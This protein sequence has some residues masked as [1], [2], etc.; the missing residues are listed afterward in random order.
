MG[1]LSHICLAFVLVALTQAKRSANVEVKDDTTLSSECIQSIKNGNYKQ[2]AT[3]LEA[4][5]N[6]NKLWYIVKELSKSNKDNYFDSL[7]RFSENVNSPTR[8]FL[9]YMILYNE[10]ESCDTINVMHLL[11]LVQQ[12]RKFSAST[13]LVNV[14]ELVDSIHSSI[15]RVI[16]AK[17]IGEIM[18]GYKKFSKTTT[19]TLNKI[20]EYDQEF[21]SLIVKAVVMELNEKIDGSQILNIFENQ[22]NLPLKT[23]GILATY[24]ALKKSNFSNSDSVFALALSIKKL[25]DDDGY[26]KKLPL[27]IRDDIETI[28]HMIPECARNV[29]FA[30]KTCIKSTKF[31]EYLYAP[32]GFNYDKQRRRV[33]TW[34]PGNKGEEDQESWIFEPSDGNFYI[35]NVAVNEYLYAAI[36]LDFDKDRRR[37]LTWIPGGREEKGQEYWKLEIIRDV[38]YIK[39]VKYDEYLYPIIGLNYDESRRQVATWKPKGCDDQCLWKIEDCSGYTVIDLDVRFGDS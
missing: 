34:I 26:N 20:D 33:F 2:A 36:G 3:K 38:C 23:W 25:K 29:V 15:Q 6:D 39:S 14:K 4:I 28:K 30:A 32:K 18:G 7:L 37:V 17:L 12:I 8:R 13:T 5:S 19:R 16:R 21:L 1:L 27:K 11:K 22:S 10:L 35:K 31:N 9:L 24:E